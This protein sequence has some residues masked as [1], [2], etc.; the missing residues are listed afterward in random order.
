MATV[1]SCRNISVF[2]SDPSPMPCH[3]FIWPANLKLFGKKKVLR[4]DDKKKAIF[5]LKNQDFSQDP[6][7]KSNA[8]KNNAID[9]RYD[10]CSDWLTGHRKSRLDRWMWQIQQSVMLS[11]RSEVTGGQRRYTVTPAVEAGWGPQQVREALPGARPM[12]ARNQITYWPC[13]VSKTASSLRINKISDT[14]KASGCKAR[15]N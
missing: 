6:L 13:L 1:A 14:V 15:C 11:D 12:Q 2:L 10:A 4:F 7:A 5:L 3:L 9:N 8:R